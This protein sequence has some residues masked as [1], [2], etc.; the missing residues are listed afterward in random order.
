MTT[1]SESLR[2]AGD[3]LSRSGVDEPFRE[4]SSLLQFVLDKDRT[5]LIAHPEYELVDD[6]EAS[7]NEA[8]RRRSA[9]EPF[10]HITG[11]KEFYGLEFLV[12]ADVLI[13]RPETEMLVEAAID[14]LANGRKHF[15][16]IG[17]GSGCIAVSIL[18]NVPASSAIGLEISLAAIA[19][20]EKNAAL[21]GV[22]DRLA[23]R[24]SDLFAALGDERFD[25]I[26]SNPPYIP[27]ADLAG[28]Q[29]EVK[30]FE[31]NTALTDGGNGLSLISSIIET[32]PRHLHP[33]GTLLIEIGFG[34]ADAVGRMLDSSRFRHWEIVP[35][36]Q[37]I[38]RMVKAVFP[39]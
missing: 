23:I 1:I 12:S 4:A 35:D 27:A 13:P 2:L 16:E 29:P 30:L 34:Q 26:V 17:V 39:E 28:L 37:Q 36:L 21:N 7:F 31:P 33:G 6:E 10:H 32:S 22:S 25:L 3:E 38:P 5:F 11:T 15:C 8:V 20:A 24:R 19:V 18:K 9:R 14:C